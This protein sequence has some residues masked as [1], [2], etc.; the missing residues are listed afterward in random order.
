MSEYLTLPEA[1][2]RVT[3]RRPHLST[4]WRWATRGCKGIRLQTVC[5]GVKR[6]TTIEWVQSFIQALTEQRNA[7]Q[8]APPMQPPRQQELAAKKSAKRLAERLGKG[9]AK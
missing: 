9:G 5:V 8:L 6:L 3:G 1:V 7:D 2:E 4:S